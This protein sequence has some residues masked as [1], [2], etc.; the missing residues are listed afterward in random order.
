MTDTTDPKDLVL[1]RTKRRRVQTKYPSGASTVQ[2]TVTDENNNLV[3]FDETHYPPTKMSWLGKAIVAT[4][5]TLV[6][7]GIFHCRHRTT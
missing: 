2:T 5:A 7:Y 6:A 4:T 1:K 3:L